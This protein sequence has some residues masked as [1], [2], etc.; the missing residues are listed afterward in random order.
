MVHKVAKAGRHTH[1]EVSFHFGNAAI[2]SCR[3]GGF[4]DKTQILILIL[5]C[6]NNVDVHVIDVRSSAH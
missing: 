2:A 4:P 6:E 1:C 5:I 3:R